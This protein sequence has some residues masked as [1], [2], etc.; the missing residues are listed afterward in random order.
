ML[1]TLLPIVTEVRLVQL[2][3]ALLPIFVTGKPLYVLGIT[4]SL[5][6]GEMQAITEY[7]LPSSL[8]VNV[9]TLSLAASA[10][11]TKIPLKSS[12]LS[13]TYAGLKMIVIA[14]SIDKLLFKNL[15]I[16]NTP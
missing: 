2:E 11:T 14:R 3:K 16:P 9:K 7:D 15:V 8:R 1:V 5:L 6:P 12:S 4:S 13:P 10:L